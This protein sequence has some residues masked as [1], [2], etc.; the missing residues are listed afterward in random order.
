MA[1]YRSA[2]AKKLAILQ[3]S[4][5][6]VSL[7]ESQPRYTKIAQ[8]LRSNTFPDDKLA[9][10]R[11]WVNYLEGLDSH[12]LVVL[13]S[14]VL[15]WSPINSLDQHCPTLKNL[16]HDLLH[17]QHVLLVTISRAVVVFVAPDCNIGSPRVGDT[18][19]W[20]N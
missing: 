9:M 2:L 6:P 15:I 7:Q 5:E 3:T 10:L 12:Q 16:R 14:W 20:V 19:F 4:E 13:E 11:M 8:V 1:C 17:A 18:Q